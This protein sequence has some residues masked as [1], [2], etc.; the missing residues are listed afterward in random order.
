MEGLD[1]AIQMVYNQ[2]TQN[3][4]VGQGLTQEFYRIMTYEQSK[5]LVEFPS[6]YLETKLAGLGHP[7][8]KV[9]APAN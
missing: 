7:E 5:D 4:L 2:N 8:T 6:D 1:P 3:T 9:V